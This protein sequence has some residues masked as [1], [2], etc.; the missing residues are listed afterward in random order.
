MKQE[1]TVALI[2]DSLA[3]PETHMKT[4][5]FRCTQLKDRVVMKASCP[6]FE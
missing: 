3:T 4:R 1:V 6:S 5:W 2:P